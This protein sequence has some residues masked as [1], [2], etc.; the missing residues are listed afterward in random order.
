[1]S[2]PDDLSQ[3]ARPILVEICK[4]LVRLGLIDESARAT[5]FINEGTAIIESGLRE[6]LALIVAERD[7]ARAAVE[8]LQAAA[9]AREALIAQLEATGKA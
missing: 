9:K 3:R 5:E 6:A 2:E 1:M 4:S 8:V 7:E